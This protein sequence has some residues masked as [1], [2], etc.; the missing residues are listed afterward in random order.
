MIWATARKDLTPNDP[1]MKGTVLFL[2]GLFILG[3]QGAAASTDSPSGWYLGVGIGK[4]EV[5][6]VGHDRS[7]LVLGTLRKDG[8]PAISAGGSQDDGDISYSVFT[9][10]SLG[11]RFSGWRTGQEVMT[12]I[13]S[14][15]KVRRSFLSRQKATRYCRPDRSW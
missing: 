12:R 5:E 1:K 14:R 2:L 9:G 3:A 15:R 4:T 6:V 11:F 7:E 10:Y 8:I 13:R